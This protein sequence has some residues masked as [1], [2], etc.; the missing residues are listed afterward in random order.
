MFLRLGFESLENLWKL[1]LKTPRKTRSTLVLINGTSWTFVVE[2]ETKDVGYLFPRWKEAKDNSFV[3]KLF[4][5]RMVSLR[6]F[7][8][9]IL[10]FKEEQRRYFNFLRISP[11]IEKRL[12]FK[13]TI[14]RMLLNILLLRFFQI[15]YN[16]KFEDCGRIKYRDFEKKNRNTFNNSSP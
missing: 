2:V 10:H 9:E 3:R 5:F 13:Q 8:S 11:K 1:K 7:G 6:L 14:M 12:K 16:V 15:D 4:A